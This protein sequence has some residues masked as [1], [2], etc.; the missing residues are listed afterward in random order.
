MLLLHPDQSKRWRADGNI[1]QVVFGQTRVRVRL[2]SESGKI[3][4]NKADQILLQSVMEKSPL[5]EDKRAKLIGAIIDW[6]DGDDLLSLEGAEKDEYRKAGLKYQPRNKPFQSLEELQMVL[7]MNEKIF[8]WL[9][10][11]IT[12]YSGQAKV[13]TKVASVNVLKLLPGIDAGLLDTYLA[14]RLESART[15]QPAPEFSAGLATS[16]IGAG[17]LGGVGGLN[18]TV[19]IVSEALLPESSRAMIEAI[20][21]KSNTNPLEPYK[22]LKWQ[23]NP[24]N[25]E[26]LFTDAMSENLVNRYAETAL[27]D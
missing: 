1:Y 14:S 12:V 20:V 27:R 3:D 15:G 17:G 22:I 6:R 24:I 11:L 10:P 19:T 26:S 9:Q 23:R 18:E 4:I 7:G 5:E 21:Q 25:Q 2:L 16:R 13:N 8:N